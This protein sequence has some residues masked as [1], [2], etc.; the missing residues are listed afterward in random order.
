[1]LASIPSALAENSSWLAADA[2][3]QDRLLLVFHLAATS[4]CC[5]S[6]ELAGITR[7]STRNVPVVMR[8]AAASGVEKKLL[9]VPGSQASWFLFGPT[10]KP[11]PAVT[12]LLVTVLPL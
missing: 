11:M 6:A 4:R 1:M 12:M 5:A 9:F 3:R 2:K 7:P 8:F 10:P